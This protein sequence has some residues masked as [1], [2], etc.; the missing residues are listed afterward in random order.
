MAKRRETNFIV[1]VATDD[2]TPMTRWLYENNI[3]INYDTED[4][5]IYAMRQLCAHINNQ[6]TNLRNI[7]YFKFRNETDAATFKLAFS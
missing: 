7:Y 3:E 6:P 1:A 4:P 5:R 2:H